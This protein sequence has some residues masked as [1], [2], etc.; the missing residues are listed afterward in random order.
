MLFIEVDRRYFNGNDCNGHVG[1]K[2]KKRKK[3]RK[4]FLF[5][6]RYKLNIGGL[7]FYRIACFSDRV[8]KTFL[9]SS[10]LYLTRFQLLEQYLPYLLIRLLSGCSFTRL[11]PAICV[12]GSESVFSLSTNSRLPSLML[13]LKEKSINSHLTNPISQITIPCVHLL[14]ERRTRDGK[15]GSDI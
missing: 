3:G 8:S 1:L 15:E 14:S 5:S 4:R 12:R 6:A 10:S 7:V 11:A 2:K 9:R 13:L